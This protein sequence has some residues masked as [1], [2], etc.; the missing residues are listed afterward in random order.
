[1][2]GDDDKRHLQCE[3][4]QFP[5]TSPPAIDHLRQARRRERDAGYDH[6]KRGDECEDERIGHPALRPVGQRERHAREDSGFLTRVRVS[7]GTQSWR[8]MS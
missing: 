7:C 5:E 6:D 4:D 8:V 3:W 1:M 2:P